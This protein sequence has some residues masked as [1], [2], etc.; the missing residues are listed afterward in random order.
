MK[1][2]VRLFVNKTLTSISNPYI[3]DSSS[4]YRDYSFFTLKSFWYPSKPD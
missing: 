2:R 4:W 1:H 3:L